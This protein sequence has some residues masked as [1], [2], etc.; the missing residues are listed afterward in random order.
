MIAKTASHPLVTNLRLYY[1][2]PVKVFWLIE[3][4][5]LAV[6]DTG[7]REAEEEADEMEV[8]SPPLV[9]VPVI[10]SSDSERKFESYDLAPCK[11]K[12]A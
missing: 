9:N 2:L 11:G 7:D 8:S 4:S 1:L 6:Q 10:V 5:G 3:L 12:Y